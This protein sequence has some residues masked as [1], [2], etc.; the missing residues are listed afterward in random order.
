M[1]HDPRLRRLATRK[2]TREL[3]NSAARLRE[4]WRSISQGDHAQLSP[5]L[6]LISSLAISGASFGYPAVTQQ[7]ARLSLAL[8][9]AISNGFKGDLRPLGA[10]IDRL[11]VEL[12]RASAQASP[13]APEAPRLF[14][15]QH[16]TVYLVDGD[17]L[18]AEWLSGLLYKSNFTVTLVA[19]A[20]A[21]AAA[22]TA[23]TPLAILFSTEH[24]L[25]LE[26][27][28][29]ATRAKTSALVGV[30]LIALSRVDSLDGR[31]A[32]LRQG[33]R[34][35]LVKPLDVNALIALLDHLADAAAL[36]R[37]R[38][39][40]LGRN[41]AF[42]SEALQAL[43]NTGF[44]I[45]LLDHPE[46]LA[47]G[48]EEFRP[49]LVIIDG[50][51]EEVRGIEVAR[52]LRMDVERANLPLVLI[53]P[54]D[55]YDAVDGCTEHL[56]G[57]LVLPCPP[58]PESMAAL[59]RHL[60]L[61]A[62]RVDQYVNHL[63]HA[64]RHK[65]LHD[66]LTGLPNRRHLEKRLELEI[67]NIHYGV[68][69]RLALLLLDIDNF[70]YVNDAYGHE[71]GDELIIDL[72]KRLA[73]F[74]PERALLSRQGG[75]EFAVLLTGMNE[76]APLDAHLQRLMKACEA[77]FSIQGDEVRIAI[78]IGAVDYTR[79][80]GPATE[81]S[82]IKQA[83]TALFRAKGAGRN[84]YIVFSNDMES[85]LRR[86]LTLLSDLRQ[87]LERDE[88]YLVYQ[89]QLCLRTGD[90][91]GAEVLLRWQH[92]RRGPI[93]PGEFIPL[94]EAH[95]LIG[96]L[97]NFVLRTAIQQIAEWQRKFG[98]VIR[99][100]VNVSPRQFSE[101]EFVRQV[102]TLLKFAGVDGRWLELEITESVLA[103]DLEQAVG[104]LVQLRDLSVTTAIDD[105]G[106]G[107]SNL[108][109]LKRYPVDL[110][111]IDRSF[112]NGLPDQENDIAIV[113]AIIQ[114]ARAMGLKLLAEGVET[115]AQRDKLKD[116][117]CDYAQGFLFSRPISRTDFETQYLM[118]PQ[119]G[120]MER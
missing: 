33:I 60:V 78:S 73:T 85:E 35:Q 20:D 81:K 6:E 49:S 13:A 45:R 11:E 54:E 98:R 91:I 15:S 96:E 40:F 94:A 76:G 14:L 89:P 92:P 51:F 104:K 95:G 116:F 25:E 28:L 97:G 80:C 88:L 34:H 9:M 21:L 106:T 2:K 67:R 120:I 90:I 119:A 77:P 82:L 10:G 63:F 31:I 41:A 86:Q 65:E 101:P 32:A 115:E 56:E 36:E 52:A 58:H 43:Q 12:L 42:A 117:Q 111:K 22:L 70:Q 93:S 105:F 55:Q 61:R 44:E 113:N 23:Q 108:A 79:A 47:S 46:G 64:I 71:A 1:T 109:S 69:K 39:L 83:D 53:L 72:A 30:P 112:V 17:E 27:L 59:V 107:F 5:L 62:R 19:Q 99:L 29:E 57:D 38:V 75:D 102:A 110:L 37:P 118:T 4:L 16:R 100:A 26:P 7:S 74:L 18:H 8:Q 87:A 68:R 50:D 48:L 24:P 84:G 103:S 114:L 66:P 3:K